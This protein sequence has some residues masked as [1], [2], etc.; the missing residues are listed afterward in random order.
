MLSLAPAGAGAEPSGSNIL[1]DAPDL[2]GLYHKSMRGA[3]E[4]L[5]TMRTS[6]RMHAPPRPAP[7]RGVPVP[8]PVP[9][10]APAVRPRAPPQGVPGREGAALV[11]RLQQMQGT[12][13]ACGYRDKAKAEKAR[14]KEERERRRFAEARI[15][16]L[17][18]ELACLRAAPAP[19]I[20]E[21][22][23]AEE[24]D[25][26]DEDDEDE[27][28]SRSQ[29]LETRRRSQRKVIEWRNRAVTGPEAPSDRSV[30]GRDDES[31][32][33]LVDYP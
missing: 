15:A 26:D 20:K 8:T 4:S 32:F 12:N 9:A 27:D 22:G 33:E 1:L 7:W 10:P 21:A 18:A 30:T 17:E 24:Y 11:M 19:S 28:D 25:V 3:A 13:C 5:D 29:F 2:R 6:L 16:A 23:G 14:G 31:T